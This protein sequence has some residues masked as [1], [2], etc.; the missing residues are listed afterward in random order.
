M[1]RSRSSRLHVWSQPGQIEM[2]D[3]TPKSDEVRM[4]CE[5][6]RDLLYLYACDELE[7]E[8]KEAVETHLADCPECTSA[9]EEHR[10]M[11]KVLPSGF[12]NRKLFYYSKNA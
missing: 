4:R 2:T 8:E 7:P 10:L 3:E 5:E 6:V 1:L 12:M 11:R 9:L